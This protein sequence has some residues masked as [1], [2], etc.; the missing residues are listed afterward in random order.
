M[1]DGLHAR[2]D[3]FTSHAVVAGALGVIAGFRLAD[4]LV[5]LLITIAILVVLRGAA[6]DIYRRLMDAVDPAP[7]EQAT[8]TVS[9]TPGVLGIEHVR[10]RW[11]GHRIIADAGIVVPH[12]LDL[13][14]AHQI[15]HTAQHRLLHEIVK[16]ADATLHVSPAAATGLDPHAEVAHHELSTQG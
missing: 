5:G 13:V 10:L 4:P 15:A 8:A 2:T 3:G 9:S 16:L 14:A 7:T 12:D 1:D 11:I 6:R